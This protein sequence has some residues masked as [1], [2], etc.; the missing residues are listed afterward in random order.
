MFAILAGAGLWSE[1]LNPWVQQCNTDNT[2]CQTFWRKSR[3]AYVSEN[4]TLSGYLQSIGAYAPPGAQQE[5]VPVAQVVT[6][7][8]SQ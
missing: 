1:T 2:D 3:T 7:M 4:Q 5:E 6:D 8:T